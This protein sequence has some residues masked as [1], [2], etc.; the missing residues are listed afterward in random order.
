MHTPAS[1]PPGAHEEPELNNERDLPT[2]GDADDAPPPRD[3]ASAQARPRGTETQ[4]EGRQAADGS[5]ADVAG[6]ESVVGEEDPGA[7]LDTKPDDPDA[8]R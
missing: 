1:A 2:E 4:V 5:R 6:R 7:A 3:A 8:G